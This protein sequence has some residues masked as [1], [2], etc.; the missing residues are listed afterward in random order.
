MRIS[1]NI[2][3]N[4]TIIAKHTSVT[5]VISITTITPHHH[6]HHD[7]TRV[8]KEQQRRNQNKWTSV[9]D[10]MDH[11]MDQV[12]PWGLTKCLLQVIKIV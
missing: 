6:Y 7:A 2:T 8:A 10:A 3:V 1:I 12:D 11:A 5:I 9:D 4:T